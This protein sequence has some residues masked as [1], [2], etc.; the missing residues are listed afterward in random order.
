MKPHENSNAAA[1]M[2]G[3]S[4]SFPSVAK[5][6]GYGGVL[7]FVALALS[8]ALGFDLSVLGVADATGKLLGYGAVIISFIGA[9]HWG[10]ALH[11]ERNRQTLLY[12]YSVVPALVAWG[13]LFVAAGSAMFG[14]ALTLVVMFFADRFL[15]AD[16]V[17]AGYLKMRMHLTIA[18]ALCLLLASVGV[19]W[20]AQESVLSVDC[21]VARVVKCSN[22]TNAVSYTHLTL[23]TTPYV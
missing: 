21:P 19:A 16:L 12:V 4:S 11:A 18:V 1:N 6:L 8:I 15:L 10:L 9:V 20:K 3:G 22:A 14:M 7:P 2:T 13:W 5:W 23:P 17:P